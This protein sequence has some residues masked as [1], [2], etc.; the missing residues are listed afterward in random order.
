MRVVYEID[1]GEQHWIS[2]ESEEE[3]VEVNATLYGYTPEQYRAEFEPVVTMLPDNRVLRVY[4]DE[5]FRDPS[6]YVERTASEWAICE[7]GL[8]GTTAC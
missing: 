4:T 7:K 8:I 5:P 6:P 2:A 1:D 3:A